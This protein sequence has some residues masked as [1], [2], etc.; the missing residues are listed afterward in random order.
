[1]KERSKDC[2]KGGNK[3]G[4]VSSSKMFVR[5]IWGGKTGLLVS[6]FSTTRQFKMLQIRNKQHQNAE[7]KQHHTKGGFAYKLSKNRQHKLNKKHKNGRNASAKLTAQC[8]K[9]V[10]LGFNKRFQA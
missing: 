9:W 5:N 1:M 2:R 3:Y 6:H 10:I 4:E 7:S 8:K